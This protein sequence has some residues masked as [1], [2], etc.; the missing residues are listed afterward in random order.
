MSDEVRTREGIR[1]QRMNRDIFP[2][3]GKGWS[4]EWSLLASRL[5]GN[6]EPITWMGW[7]TGIGGLVAESRGNGK[8]GQSAYWARFDRGQ[9]RRMT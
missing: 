9:D 5:E 8:G 2:T 7:S 1:L 3:H 6:P 4:E